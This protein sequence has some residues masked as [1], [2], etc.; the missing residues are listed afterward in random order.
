MDKRIFELSKEFAELYNYYI[1]KAE[2][3]NSNSFK[4]EY[5]KIANKYAEFH[6]RLLEIVWYLNEEKYVGKTTRT[7]KDYE[8]LKKYTQI[9][10]IYNYDNG[11]SLVE[12]T[13][14]TFYLVPT[15]IIE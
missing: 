3:T 8:D 12:D 13:A 2:S 9:T 15:E 7:L 14:G 10:V 11:F 4:E 1:D 6:D 5:E